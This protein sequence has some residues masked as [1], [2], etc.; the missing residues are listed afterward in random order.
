MFRKVFKKLTALTLMLLLCLSSLPTYAFIYSPGPIEYELDRSYMLESENAYLQG[1]TLVFNKGGKIKFDLLLPFDAVNI[2]FTYEKP[3]ESVSISIETDEYSYS[4]ELAENTTSKSVSIAEICGSH[5]ITFKA[6]KPVRIKGVNFVKVN[7]NFNEANNKVPPFSDYESAVLTLVVLKEDIS[8]FKARGS[9]LRWDME[10]LYLTPK[11]INGSMYVPVAKFAEG[12]GYYCEDYQE[13]S[14]LYMLGESDALALKNGKGYYESDKDGR[15][16]IE[17]DIR[18]KDGYT[19]APVRALSELLGFTVG[20]KDG[21]VAIG[22]RLRVKEI[23]ETEKLFESLKKEL[24]T[25]EIPKE[26]VSGKTYHVAKT[27]KASDLNSGTKD[28]PFATISKAA[29]LAKAGDT[30]IIHEGTYREVLSPKNNGTTF[31]PITFCAAEG[32]N[33]VISA[34]EPISNFIKYKG[35]IVCTGLE[36][37]LGFGRNQLFYKGKALVEGRHPNQDTKEGI[38]PYPDGVSPFYATRGNMRITENGGD[39]VRSETDLNQNKEDY[40]E[41]A[42]YVTLKGEGWSLVSGEVIGSSYGQ[43]KVKDHAGTKSYN[44]GL[45]PSQAHDGAYYYKP[46]HSTDYGYLTNHINTLDLPGEWFAKN[47]VIYMIPPT[48]SDLEN[49]FEVKA[50]QRV[51]DLREKS[52]IVIKDINTI[53]GGMTMAGDTEGNVLNGGTHKYIA[54]HTILL[55]QSNYTMAKDDVF[56]ER[57]SMKAGE[58]GFYVSGKYNAII[59]ATIDHS[60]GTGIS[61]TGKYHY[62]N[63]NVV[64]NTSYSGGY[65]GG[66]HLFI[67]ESNASV[68]LKTVYGGHFVTFN[69]VYN[70]GR[71]VLGQYSST[72]AGYLG[73]SP[74]EIAYNRFFNG[75]LCTRDTGVTYEYGHTGGND[76]ARTRM[77]HNF[78]YSPGHYD[79][80]TSYLIMCLYHDGYVANRDTYSNIAYY[81]YEGIPYY[82]GYGIFQQSTEWTVLRCRNN[83]DLGYL[84]NGEFD[85]K[86]EDFPGARP[87]LPGSNHG[88]VARVYMENYNNLVNDIKEIMPISHTEDK[89]AKT[90]IYTFENIHFGGTESTLLDLYF[91]RSAAKEASFIATVRAYDKDGNLVIES[92]MANTTNQHRFYVN[93]TYKGLVVIPPVKEGDYKIELEVDDLYTEIYRIKIGGTI[94]TNYDDLFTKEMELEGIKPYYPTSVELNDKTGTETFTLENVHIEKDIN[95]HLEIHGT[96]EYGKEKTVFITSYVYNKNGELV[97]SSQMQNTLQNQK[98]NE[99]EV[100]EG[101]MILP[102]L[103]EGEYD[104]KLE[105]SDEFYNVLRVISKEADPTYN[106]LFNADVFVGGLYDDYIEGEKHISPTQSTNL[107]LEKIAT[108][109]HHAA[110]NCWDNTV[111]YRNRVIKEKAK[112]LRVSMSTGFPYAGSKVELYVDSLNSKPYATWTSQETGWLPA[113]KYIP[114]ERSLSPGTHTFYF[115]FSGK[116]L[117]STLWNFSFCN[118]EWEE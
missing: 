77:H 69:T 81:E 30:V 91:G 34:L 118:K 52:N 4:T 6:N 96:R 67:D 113:V 56:A 79:E 11:N 90:Q 42:T 98:T 61:V 75:A 9:M 107:A 109:D 103:E 29:D 20:Y 99:Y 47:N 117:C 73:F 51:I 88:D 84:P 100:V 70:G 114:L 14:Y 15:R 18:Y 112:L 65:P 48:D 50:R 17:I 24:K 21:Y 74:N 63:N 41:G 60:S 116:D 58:A 8:A 37:D 23:L 44:L 46:V 2:V 1:D 28:F 97:H 13:L 36:N 92:D 64:S 59:N 102:V 94:D 45:V 55:D 53:G 19:W 89:K 7:E 31:A 57:A 85:I 25:F 111:I 83:S 43:L 10:N 39:I 49:D 54:H 110:G 72:N 16:D 104:I 105:F 35:D 68:A 87:F 38:V 26:K 62:I 5:T 108:F 106:N 82:P 3:E 78:V 101:T 33:V 40:W 12:L 71:G 66:I 27:S 93:E 76:I 80:E 22:D 32:E 86:K 115:V 95:T